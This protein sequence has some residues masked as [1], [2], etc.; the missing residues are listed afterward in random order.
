[1]TV[2]TLVVSLLL[3]KIYES[4]AT[5]LPQ[6]ES[7]NGVGLGALFASGA[8]SSAA[9]SLGISLPGSPATPTDIFTAMLKS[10]IMQAFAAL[11]F[12]HAR[13]PGAVAHRED[14]GALMT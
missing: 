5:L 7:N 4:T 13:G 1:M 12:G 6:L 8:A 14:R 10:R 9:Q 3:P 11:V 2:G